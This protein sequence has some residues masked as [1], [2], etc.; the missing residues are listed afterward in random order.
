MEKN[1]NKYKFDRHNDTY[2]AVIYSASFSLE[3]ALKYGSNSENETIN[4]LQD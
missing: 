1:Q 4:Y 3:Q 2:T